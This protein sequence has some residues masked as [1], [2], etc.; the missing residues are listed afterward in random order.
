MFV[1]KKSSYYDLTLAF[2]LFL[3]NAIQILLQNAMA[4]LLQNATKVHY[5]MRQ[6]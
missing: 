1:K 2:I 4:I 3:Q 5:K 6:F